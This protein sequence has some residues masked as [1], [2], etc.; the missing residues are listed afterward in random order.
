[1]YLYFKQI[2]IT[3]TTTERKT[4][5]KPKNQSNN[6]LPKKIQTPHTQKELQLN[7][8]IW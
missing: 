3:T 2:Q 6:P 1:M 5:Q 8:F 4:K 7:Y